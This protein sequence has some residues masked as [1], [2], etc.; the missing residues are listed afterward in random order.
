MNYN[1]KQIWSKCFTNFVN[2]KLSSDLASA[3]TAAQTP[4]SVVINI[5]YDSNGKQVSSSVQL[6]FPDSGDDDDDEMNNARKMPDESTTN[7]NDTAEPSGSQQVVTSELR[8][9]EPQKA[10]MQNTDFSLEELCCPPPIFMLLISA[11]QVGMYFTQDSISSSGI[12]DFK[13]SQV[14][15]DPCKRHQVNVTLKH[16]IF[17]PA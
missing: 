3:S 8:T 13:N 17:K 10:A 4:S 14:V 12:T 6:E 15:Y 5:S 1:N 2:E 7:S 11:L 16:F 9:E